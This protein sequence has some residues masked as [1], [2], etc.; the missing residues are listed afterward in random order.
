MTCLKALDMEIAQSNV[1]APLHSVLKP[2][3]KKIALSISSYHAFIF[4]PVCI[5][6]PFVL[7]FHPYN[8]ENEKIKDTHID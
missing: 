5:Y 2:P 1:G 7:I 8:T 3:F 6:E 4:V